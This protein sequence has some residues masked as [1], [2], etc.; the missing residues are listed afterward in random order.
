MT[1]DTT[2]TVAQAG[3]SVTAPQLSEPVNLRHDETMKPT[4]EIDRWDMVETWPLRGARYN[5]EEDV[6]STGGC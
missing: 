3:P 5:G 1:E 2:T 6:C 4:I